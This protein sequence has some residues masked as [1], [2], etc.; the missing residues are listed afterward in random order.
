MLQAKGPC[1]RR[2]FTLI[3]LLVVIAIIAILAGMLLPA[4]SRA[5]EKGR[6]TICISNLKQ[7][8]LTFTLYAGDFADTFPGCASKLP[9]IP[10]EEDWIYWNVNDSRI[11]TAKRRDPQNGA[12]VPYLGKFQ[13]NLFRCPSDRDVKQRE[14][15]PRP[16]QLAYLFSYT[17]NSYYDPVNQENHGIT[18]LFPGD[19]QLDNIPFKSAS[20]RNPS[21]KIMLAEELAGINDPDDGRWTPTTNRKVGLAHPIPFTPGESYISNRHTG[22][23]TVVMADGHVE[24][25][26]P[27]FGNMPEHFDALY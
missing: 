18:S 4:L 23:G 17:A 27:S 5:K 24:T 20:I 9:T 11:S 10:V 13:T 2:G 7:I 1:R 19:P 14:A 8:G 3:E 12:I 21:E 25:V 26:R 16:G 6:H 22:K 15:N